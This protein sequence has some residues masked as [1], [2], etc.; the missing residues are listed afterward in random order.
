MIDYNAE[1]LRVRRSFMFISLILL[2]INYASSIAVSLLKLGKLDSEDDLRTIAIIIS[3]IACYK[4]LYYFFRLKTDTYMN[5]RMGF[6]KSS[7]ERHTEEGVGDLVMSKDIGFDKFSKNYKFDIQGAILHIN[8][9]LDDLAQKPPPHDSSRSMLRDKQPAD[10]I[11][12]LG[13]NLKQV[14]KVHKDFSSFYQ[15][16]KWWEYTSRIIFM[17]AI[18]YIIFLLAIEMS[19]EISHK[20]FGFNF[21]SHISNYI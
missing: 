10:V 5:K 18:P 14:I 20:T 6:T 16:E 3:A 17:Y 12:E 21:A 11:A 8:R 9:K 19:F 4:A 13:G 2:A 15:K 1:T 7:I